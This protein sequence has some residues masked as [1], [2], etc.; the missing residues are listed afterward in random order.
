MSFTRWVLFLAFGV[1]VACGNGTSSEPQSTPVAAG[2]GERG[3][4][5]EAQPPPPPS[6]PEPPWPSDMP[7]MLACAS[8][9][10]CVY[11]GAHYPTSPCCDTTG[12]RGV[13]RDW[14]ERVLALREGP[15]CEAV[16]CAPLE[17]PSAAQHGPGVPGC[18]PVCREQT[19]GFVCD[20]P[21]EFPVAR[22]TE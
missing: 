13:R 3:E 22:P 6:R 21:S 4:T 8:D 5:A 16:R 15:T 1:S 20:V 12:E 14:Y 10:E 2:A 19:C 18:R 11:V 7:P 17:L 9:D